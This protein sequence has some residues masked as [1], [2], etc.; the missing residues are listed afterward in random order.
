MAKQGNRS[1]PP[2][3]TLSKPEPPSRERGPRRTNLL[4]V[5]LLVIIAVLVALLFRP[6]KLDVYKTVDEVEFADPAL[7]ACVRQ[8]A[9]EHGWQDVGHIVSLRCN[10]PT[11]NAVVSLDG[12]E[13]LVSLADVNLAFNAIT[14]IGP[15]AR[16][17]Q[18]AVLDL[19]HNQLTDV[20]VLRAA[21]RLERLELNYNQ[22][23]S[24]QWLGN[25][26]FLVLHSLS[27]AHNS[28]ASLDAIRAVPQLREL[29]VRSNRISDVEPL[30][31]LTDLEL[32]DI[33][34]NG[35][36]S[37]EGFGALAV[38]QR[39]FLDRNELRSTRGLEGLSWLEELD[40]SSNPQRLQRLDL[41]HTTIENL[42]GVLSL[43]DIEIL[44]LH[45]DI[46]LGCDAIHAAE[47]EFGATAV[48]HDL[49]CDNGS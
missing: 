5:L 46:S 9:A 47:E 8:A 14:D 27:I 12:I 24:L 45:G 7:A 11:G 34:S 29:N 28:I 37:A 13:H 31:A 41:S 3:A 33:G 19:S 17:P 30:F 49:D 10:H 6:V 48:R 39:L 32:V 16:L 36:S 1:D 43:G 15:L 18:L 35:V 4:I 22:F 2:M 42:S 20:P 21:D 38:L 23:E 40:L 25:Q 44:R 26:R